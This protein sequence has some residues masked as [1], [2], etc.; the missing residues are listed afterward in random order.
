MHLLTYLLACVLTHLLTY[1]K[2]K[3]FQRIK[4]RTINFGEN[5]FGR[6]FPIQ[7][8]EILRKIRFVFVENITFPRSFDSIL[9]LR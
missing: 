5:I 1:I 2:Y 7:T 6:I 9:G 3:S 4:F 8:D